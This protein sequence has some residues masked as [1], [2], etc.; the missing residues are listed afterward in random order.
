MVLVR[1][2]TGSRDRWLAAARI[3]LLGVTLLTVTGCSLRQ[4]AI[5]TL[6][7]ALAGSS[8]SFTSDE[9]PELVRDA[10]P[11]ALKTIETLL[12]EA[13]DNRG[14]LISACQGFVLYGAG[15]VGFEAERLEE[16]N[17]RE[18]K[19]QRERSLKLLLRA[20]GYCFEALDLAYPGARQ[21]L[22][23]ATDEAL[24]QTRLEDVTLLYW[25]A[26]A[27]GSV[28]ASGLD[29]PELLVDL[30][31]VRALLERAMELEPTYKRGTLHDAMMLLELAEMQSGAG[32]KERAREYLERSL[33]LS[34]GHRAVSYVAWASTVAV[35]DQ[36]RAEFKRLLELALAVDLK[37]DPESRLLNVLQ[38]DRARWLL[39]RADELFLDD[40]EEVSG[41]D[42]P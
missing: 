34:G 27:W 32:S 10:L 14:L 12:A 37:G 3:G 38:Q 1:Y 25:T 42:G 13:P 36:D 15:F 6:A 7:D 24:A 26:A 5:N 40:L 30:P 35:Q 22:I 28:I 39:E 18:S 41:D 2:W 31:A 9:D 23:N 11:F 4:M 20:R 21:A 19:R 16:S 8:E 29:Q 33:E 17:Y